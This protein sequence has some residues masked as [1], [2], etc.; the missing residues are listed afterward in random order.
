[1]IADDEKSKQRREDEGAEQIGY[2]DVAGLL[3]GIPIQFKR[4]QQLIN[5]RLLSSNAENIKIQKEV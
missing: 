2:E 5:K 3:A 1:L 4:Q